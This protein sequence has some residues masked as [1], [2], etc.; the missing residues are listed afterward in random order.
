MHTVTEP[1]SRVALGPRTSVRPAAAVGDTRL[2]SSASHASRSTDGRLLC[3]EPCPSLSD[4]TGQ[5]VLLLV[6]LDRNYF[7]VRVDRLRLAPGNG[8]M[9]TKKK[10]FGV[11]ACTSLA[12]SR[13]F[14]RL[15]GDIDNIVIRLSL[16]EHIYI[17]L[18]RGGTM[19]FFSHPLNIPS[20]DILRGEN[21]P[22]SRADSATFPNSTLVS[23]C[24]RHGKWEDVSLV[25]NERGGRGGWRMMRGGIS[26]IAPTSRI[27]DFHSHRRDRQ[28]GQ[29]LCRSS[30]YTTIP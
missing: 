21:G 5:A 9:E 26:L 12:C 10:E 25:G 29:H 3:F 7:T 8:K 16:H 19:L 14:G 17:D 15:R 13:S 30:L 1:T 6:W 2:Y 20:F 28:P 4:F 23:S 18:G 27:L 22:R 11:F 24:G